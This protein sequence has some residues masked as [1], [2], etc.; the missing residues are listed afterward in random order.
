VLRFLL[1]TLG[2][3]LAA[4]GDDDDGT[5]GNAGADGPT[6][7]I[8]LQDTMSFEPEVLTVAPGDEVTLHLTNEGAIQHNFSIEDM[9]I[10]VDV[11]PGAT[12][13]V[14]FTA[15]GDPGEHT[16]FCDEPGHEGAGMT[17]TLVV[18]R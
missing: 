3:L 18:E 9:D 5:P 7:E 2:L 10:S 16:I 6:F 1:V 8:A 12:E 14:E 15:P 11:A 17:G 4:C 13:N